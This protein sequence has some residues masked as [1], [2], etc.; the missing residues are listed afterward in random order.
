[1]KK[2]GISVFTIFVLALFAGT[3]FYFINTIRNDYKNGIS[4]SENTFKEIAIFSENTPEKVTYE[5]FSK[6]SGILSAQFSHNNETVIAYPDEETS[7]QVTNS[8]LVKVFNK[9]IVKDE[10]IYELKL[11]VYLLRPETIYSTAKNA[12]FLILFA[13]LATIILLIVVSAKESKRKEDDNFTEADEIKEENYVENNSDE[14]NEN[15]DS[16]NDDVYENSTDEEEITEEN[17]D[18]S[19]ENGESESEIASSEA[20]Y[21]EQKVM[22]SAMP[23]KDPITEEELKNKI[24]FELTKAA[25]NEADLSLFLLQFDNPSSIDSIESYLCNNYGRDNVFN[26]S[27]NV[28]ALIKEDTT[29]DEAEDLAAA[30]EH[31]I[32]AMFPETTVFIGISSRAIRMLSAERLL[33]EA[34]EALKHTED[35][36]DSHIIGFHVDI[37]KYREFLKNS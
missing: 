31:E 3:I 23:E 16:E 36:D 35:D 7:S 20:Y 17:N 1:M 34:E 13:T 24:N 6:D 8:G 15:I 10:D 4:R 18:K 9:T 2:A 28:Y 26:Y 22:E 21:N 29:I 27:E 19:E 14:I 12:F 33:M 11:A 32:K 30:I 37:E 25:S 5:T